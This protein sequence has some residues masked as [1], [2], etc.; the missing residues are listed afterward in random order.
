M[1]ER[2]PVGA[3]SG[4]EQV[5]QNHPLFDHLGGSVKFPVEGIT[6]P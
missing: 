4:R 6:P 2:L 5:Q 1:P 3:N